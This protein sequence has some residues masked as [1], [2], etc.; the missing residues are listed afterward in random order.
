LR[1]SSTRSEVS[2][3]GARTTTA[4][5]AGSCGVPE[6]GKCPSLGGEDANGSGTLAQRYFL[7]GRLGPVYES[8]TIRA[9][10]AGRFPEQSAGM[11]I[12]IEEGWVSRRK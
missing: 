8:P 9:K 1:I 12:I 4:P 11:P 5:I 6:T 3:R 10:Q 7:E 2:S